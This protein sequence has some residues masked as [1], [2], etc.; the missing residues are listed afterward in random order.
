VELSGIVTVGSSD[1]VVPSSMLEFR[2]SDTPAAMAAVY[3]CSTDHSG[4]YVIKLPAPD[5]YLAALPNVVSD[6]ASRVRIE[7]TGLQPKLRYD[8][9]LAI[10]GELLLTLVE[11]NGAAASGALLRIRMKEPFA[12]EPLIV[13]PDENGHWRGALGAGEYYV[14][15]WD[16]K[17]NLMATTTISVRMNQMSE[18][19]LNLTKIQGYLEGRVV[20]DETKKGIPDAKVQVLIDGTFLGGFGVSFLTFSS[21]EGRFSAPIEASNSYY[22]YVTANGYVEGTS[23]AVTFSQEVTPRD[24]LMV[25]LS[26]GHD[27][28]GVVLDWLDQPIAR[29]EVHLERNLLT[30]SKGISNTVLR[31]DAEGKF[32]LGGVPEGAASLQALDTLSS[33]DITTISVPAP[34]I[35]LRMNPVSAI[36]GDVS[37][38]DGTP[39]IGEFQILLMNSRGSSATNISKMWGPFQNGGGQF[40]IKGI[41]KGRYSAN[42][43]ARLSGKGQTRFSVIGG[44]SE[45]FV[46]DGVPGKVLLHFVLKRDKPQS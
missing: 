34:P 17:K 22:A 29:A 25:E 33:S 37:W 18:T 42:V 4:H 23:R 40:V 36:A 26:R 39:F 41:D 9:H 7:V 5:V 13:S 27:I 30:R 14:V 46:Y 38:P 2:Q 1:E 11:P 20:D 28:D 15:A 24:G 6:V 32:H 44:N 3:Q 45:V 21:E 35:L 12:S 10:G 19:T 8:L 43:L 31:T 16:R